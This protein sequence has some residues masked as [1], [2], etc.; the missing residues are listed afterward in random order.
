MQNER[1]ATGE[2][3]QDVIYTP[4]MLEIT[5]ASTSHAGCKNSHALSR[6]Q[7]LI[8]MFVNKDTCNMWV[9]QCIEFSMW[10][11]LKYDQ[12]LEL[13]ECMW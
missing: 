11:E 2:I 5:R 10:E 6:S 13:Q 1:A 4:S 12:H 9:H 8:E 3:S 7:L